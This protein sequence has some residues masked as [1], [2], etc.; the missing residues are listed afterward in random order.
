MR[1]VSFNNFAK[2]KSWSFVFWTGLDYS[3][4][5]RVSVCKEKILKNAIKLYFYADDKKYFKIV[6]IIL[7][8]YLSEQVLILKDHKSAKIM[9]WSNYVFLFR[10]QMSSCEILIL[11]QNKNK[12]IFII[13]FEMCSC[14]LRL[15]RLKNKEEYPTAKKLVDANLGLLWEWV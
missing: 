15:E 13:S 3:C 1:K 14:N 8:T 2:K 4:R 6:L 11:F 7:R 9:L 12:V 10:K 5:N